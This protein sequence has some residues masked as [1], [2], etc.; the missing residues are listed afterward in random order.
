MEQGSLIG[1]R[2]AVRAQ[3]GRGRW[4]VNIVD[5]DP[6]GKFVKVASTGK[7]FGQPRWVLL[8]EVMWK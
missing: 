3:S 8:S 7:M 6:S 2:C 4:W 5:A 1:R